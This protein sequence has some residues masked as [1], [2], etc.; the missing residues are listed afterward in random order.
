MRRLINATQT[1]QERKLKYALCL[2]LGDDAAT[3]RR[4]RDITC[5][6]IARHHGF[7]T[8]GQMIDML[9]LKDFL[10]AIKN[11]RRKRADYLANK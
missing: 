1:P 9:D 8:F 3:A 4:R 6:K 7:M 5:N 2:A 11:I 10:K